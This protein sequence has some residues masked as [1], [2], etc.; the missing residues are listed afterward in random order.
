MLRIGG[1]C[2]ED[3]YKIIRAAA[4]DA[5]NRQMRAQHRAR[6]SQEDYEKACQTFQK[7]YEEES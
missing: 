6:W 2:E 3:R 7:L 1:M 5:G 4:T